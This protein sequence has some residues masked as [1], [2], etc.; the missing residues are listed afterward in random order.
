V[1]EE[2]YPQGTLH[3]R[4]QLAKIKGVDSEGVLVGSYPPD[5]VVKQ[6]R[7]LQLHKPL[8]FT[9]EAVQNPDVLGRRGKP[10]VARFTYR[11]SARGRAAEKFSKAYA[12][13]F[14]HAPE[15]FAAE[16]YDIVRVLADAIAAGKGTSISGESLRDFLRQVRN[17][18]AASGTITFDKKGDV[19]KPDAIRTI[20]AG[21][22]KT[23]VIK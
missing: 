17:Y 22:P 21:S 8:F 9:T 4:A 18:P 20:E 2:A 15:L 16:G 6:A 13:K 11:S 1:F 23:L 10:P 12:A 3:L 7:E 19:A 5:T 14:G